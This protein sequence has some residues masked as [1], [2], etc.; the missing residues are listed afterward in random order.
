MLGNKMCVTD[1]VQVL[2][3]C[4]LTD[5]RTEL[6]TTL[7]DA[8]DDLPRPDGVARP[9]VC[10]AND[11]LGAIHAVHLS[12]AGT[13]YAWTGTRA[14]TQCV[15]VQYARCGSGG[16]K[17]WASGAISVD[18]FGSECTQRSCCGVFWDIGRGFLWCVGFGTEFGCGTEWGSESW[19]WR[20]GRGRMEQ[21]VRHMDL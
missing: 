11:A 20:W 3:V 16:E 15:A 21:A 6:E 17:L 5:A 10:A 19:S 14:G 7:D 12:D 8:D 4:S 13:G 9:G 1:F 2:G 18:A